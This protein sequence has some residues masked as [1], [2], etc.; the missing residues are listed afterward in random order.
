[1]LGASAIESIQSS[2]ATRVAVNVPGELYGLLFSGANVEQAAADLGGTAW[3]TIV[4]K[5]QRTI[6]LIILI[7]A[8]YHFVMVAWKG[9][10]VGRLVTDLQVRRL[11]RSRWER[12]VPA[13]GWKAF[14]RVNGPGVLPS[15]ARALV[16]AATG[17][18]LYGLSWIVLIHGHFGLA[19]LTWL[20]AIGLV[21]ANILF[22][23][24]G[25]RRSLSD[26]ASRTI[27]VRT[28]NYAKAAAAAERARHAALASAQIA[29]QAGRERAGRVAQSPTV[30]QLKDTGAR[31]RDQAK[32]SDSGRRLGRAGQKFAN[33][34]KDVYD[35]KR[36][37]GSGGPPGRS[38]R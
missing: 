30:R 36:D 35:E 32:A 28:L 27:V 6:L 38:D 3:R 4:S 33:R 17:S 5:V 11:D 14:K 7:E 34:V 21:V 8:A 2:V 10:T 29:A 16:T 13:R 12:P 15:L 23:L 24:L 31:W 25:K 20:A 37:A 9:R 18:G 22:A 19:F 26:R 1:V